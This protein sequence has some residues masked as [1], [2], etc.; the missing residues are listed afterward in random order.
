LLNEIESL[1]VKTGAAV[2]FAAHFPKGNVSQ[3]DS[4]DRIGGSG[5]FARDPDSI[6]TFTRHET[7]DC[8]TVE[9]TLRNHAPVAP[10]VVRWE[11]PLLVVDDSLDPTDLK[12]AGRKPETTPNDVLDLLAAKPLT[13]AEWRELA[14]KKLHISR[15]TFERRLEVIAM[16]KTAVFEDEKW[17]ATEVRR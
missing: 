16:K 3:R 9:A 2:A 12:K 14:R 1:A 17:R 7:E 15:R 4:V 5:V 13:E 10:F 6:L 8:F 11:Y